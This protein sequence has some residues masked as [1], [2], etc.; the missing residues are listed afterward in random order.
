RWGHPLHH[1]LRD[2]R[3]LNRADA[4]A[5]QAIDTLQGLDNPQQVMALTGI[6]H[7]VDPGQ[8]QLTMAARHQPMG[9]TDDVVELAAART[10]ARERD[11]A[12]STGKIAAILNLEIGPCMPLVEPDPLHRKSPRAIFR[13]CPH[14]GWPDL[15]R[16]TPHPAACI[17]CPIPTNRT[18][19]PKRRNPPTPPRP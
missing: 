10:A 12:E 15:R 14:R 17:L 9:L 4:Q 2:S 11:D 16:P 6:G 7:D 5:F 3:R 18:N 19:P 1:G 13:S 8:H